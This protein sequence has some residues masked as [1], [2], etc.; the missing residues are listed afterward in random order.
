MAQCPARVATR[1]G[2]AA[3]MTNTVSEQTTAEFGLTRTQKFLYL[4]IPI[5]LSVLILLYSPL[6]TGIYGTAVFVILGGL[7]GLMSF[8]LSAGWGFRLE[9]GPRELRILDRRQ[10]ITIPMDKIGMIVRNG[11]FPFP[12]LW[13]VLRGA[14]VGTS[15]PAKGVDPHARDLIESYQRRH[16]GK[17]VTVVPVAGGYLSSVSGLAAELKRRI[18]PL[19][20]DERLAAK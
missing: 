9:V 18:P 19:T 11:G 5:A 8:F 14:A 2:A 15:V 20:V 1:A 6:F 7:L 3:E 12:T 16:P 17:D 4:L 13:L 10:T